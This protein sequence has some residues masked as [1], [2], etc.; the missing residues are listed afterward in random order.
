MKRIPATTKNIKKWDD[1]PIVK[2]D[3]GDIKWTTKQK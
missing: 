3:K 2:L 1:I